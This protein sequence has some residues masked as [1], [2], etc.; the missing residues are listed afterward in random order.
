MDWARTLFVN[1]SNLYLPFLVTMKQ[2]AEAE[3]EGLCQIFDFYG[4]RKRAKILDLSCGIGR[5]EI[6]LARKGYRI[7]GFSPSKE[8]IKIAKVHCGGIRDR[9]RDIEFHEGSIGNVV[10][11]LREKGEGDFDVAICMFNSLGFNGSG[12]DRKTLKDLLR[13][14]VDR[15]ILVTET[16]NRDWRLK[17]FERFVKHDFNNVQIQENWEFD[18]ESSTAKS[19]YTVLWKGWQRWISSSRP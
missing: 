2:Q 5:H 10:K 15:G 14:V 9:T 13:L 3:V 12:V 1:Y 6:F 11:I 4:I 19:F 17:N 7:V 16:E 8:Y 18:L